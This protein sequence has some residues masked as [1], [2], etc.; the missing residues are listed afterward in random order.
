MEMN[1]TDMK[2]N[3]SAHTSRTFDISDQ[4]S[5]LTNFALMGSLLTTWI[6]SNREG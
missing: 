4:L 5:Q 1:R 2:H 6:V 3:E